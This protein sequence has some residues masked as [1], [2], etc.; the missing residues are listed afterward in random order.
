MLYDNSPSEKTK[1][2]FDEITKLHSNGIKHDIEGIDRRAREQYFRT[3]T[4]E[5]TIEEIDAVIEEVRT[6][7]RNRM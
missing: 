4:T 5:P 7:M 6:E 2:L 1:A 3:H